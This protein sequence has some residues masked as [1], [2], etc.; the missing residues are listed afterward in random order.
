MSKQIFNTPTKQHETTLSP[1]PIKRQNGFHY[2]Y[3]H[4]TPRKLYFSPDPSKLPLPS[5]KLLP[6][7]Q[8]DF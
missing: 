6:L 7:K 2:K 5:I 4:S 1:P 8:L 3:F